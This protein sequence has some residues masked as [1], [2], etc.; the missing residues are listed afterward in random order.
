MTSDQL[1]CYLIHAIISVFWWRSFWAFLLFAP[2]LWL[3]IS[4]W[5]FLFFTLN[6]FLWWNF[7]FWD[8]FRSL[9]WCL[10]RDLLHGLFWSYLFRFTCDHYFFFLLLYFFNRL[11]F[12]RLGLSSFFGCLFRICFFLLAL[13]SRLRV[14]CSSR[15]DFWKNRWCKLHNGIRCILY[16]YFVRNL[17]SI[18]FHPSGLIEVITLRI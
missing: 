7:L 8:L 2:F 10:F 6:R 15:D 14:S 4:I 17:N 13:S 18:F 1:I 11:L 16:E 12:L 3:F 9:F 5:F